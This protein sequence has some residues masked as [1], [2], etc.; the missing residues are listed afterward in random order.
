MAEALMY[1]ELEQ[2]D[3]STPPYQIQ[4][5]SQDHKA[6]SYRGAQAPWGTGELESIVV[7]FDT[8]WLT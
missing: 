1:D 6:R 3:R 7:Y 2:I 4:L 5:I 8:G